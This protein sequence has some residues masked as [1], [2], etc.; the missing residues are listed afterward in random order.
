MITRPASDRS[1]HSVAA[2]AA[3]IEAPGHLHLQR[4]EPHAYR[5]DADRRELCS[6]VARHWTPHCWNW[7]NAAS[8]NWCFFWPGP[9][10]M[11]TTG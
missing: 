8:H 6:A 1:V 5:A 11:K 10:R 9:I 2:L 7:T 4:A 3:W